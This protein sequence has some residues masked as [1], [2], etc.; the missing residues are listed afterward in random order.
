MRPAFINRF[1]LAAATLM[2]FASAS[3]AYALGAK[4]ALVGG[5]INVSGGQAAKSAPVFWEGIA[6]ATANK[7]GN[8]AF[9]TTVIPADCVGTV[10]DGTSSIE[11]SID[12]CSNA[13]TRLHGTGQTI[14][15][16]PGDDG[17]IRAGGALSY[18]DNGDG[19]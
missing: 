17:A 14:S 16:A 18:A 3:P 7:G 5:L 10:S 9:T 2:M 19:T 1:G 13:T 8:F 4:A 15:Y 12:G 11:V 6:V